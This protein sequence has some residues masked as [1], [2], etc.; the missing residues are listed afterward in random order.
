MSTKYIADSMQIS[1]FMSAGKKW[2]LDRD[3]FHS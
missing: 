1:I 3:L 2:N